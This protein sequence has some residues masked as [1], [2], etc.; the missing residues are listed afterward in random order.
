MFETLKN[1]R[2]KIYKYRLTNK[3]VR[4]VCLYC[5][6]HSGKVAA[7]LRKK[8]GKQLE[9]DVKGLSKFSQLF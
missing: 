3:P 4:N 5:L 9:E 7:T 2:V 6:S 1:V 8:C